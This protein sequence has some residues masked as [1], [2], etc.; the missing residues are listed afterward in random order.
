MLWRLSLV[1]KR[2]Q[3]ATGALLRIQHTVD[4]IWSVHPEIAVL[5]GPVPDRKARHDIEGTE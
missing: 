5:S 4:K 1:L 3:L 2:I